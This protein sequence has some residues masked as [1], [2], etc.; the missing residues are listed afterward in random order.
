LGIDL[1]SSSP[2]LQR[3]AMI[4]GVDCG[5][6]YVSRDILW[7]TRR[8]EMVPK[9]IERICHRGG[10][11]REAER[12]ALVSR[13]EA[14]PLAE[15]EAAPPEIGLIPKVVAVEPDGGRYQQRVWDQ[16]AAS[17]HSCAGDDALLT[18]GD[19]SSGDV[20][21]GSSAAA[22]C[23]DSAADAEPDEPLTEPDCKGCWREDKNAVLPLEKAAN[24]GNHRFATRRPIGA[25]HDGG[26]GAA[27]GP[28]VREFQGLDL[29]SCAGRA[30]CRVGTRSRV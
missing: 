19:V 18:E 11:E 13:F 22:A 8:I 1:S 14:L 15:K 4:C 30:T 12:Q 17:Q 6:F 24:L 23:A 26:T 29:C 28:V 20:G 5:S 3:V 7:T 2:E 16:L 10:Q 9:E 25:V 21:C 27:C